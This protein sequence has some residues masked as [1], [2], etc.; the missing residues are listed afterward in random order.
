VRVGRRKEKKGQ[1]APASS[2]APA[3]SSFAAARTRIKSVRHAA[4]RS[5]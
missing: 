1:E 4:E 3:G 5:S 2:L